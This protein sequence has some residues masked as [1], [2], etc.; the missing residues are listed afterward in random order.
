MLLLGLVTD[1]QGAPV[2]S[3]AAVLW[4]VGFL[5]WNVVVVPIRMKTNHAA[6][7]FELV[8]LRRI[9]AAG[10]WLA[11]TIPLCVLFSHVASSFFSRACSYSP[12]ELMGEM[13]ENLLPPGLAPP[14][15]IVALI[16]AQLSYPLMEEFFFRGRYLQLL[17][18]FFGTHS[19]IAISTILFALAHGQT[20]LFL[21][22]LIA[23][24]VYAY[25]VVGTGSIWAGVALHFVHNFFLAL[26]SSS[27]GKPIIRIAAAL[28]SFDCRRDAASAV[29]LAAVLIGVCLFWGRIVSR[30]GKQ[31]TA[32]TT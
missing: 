25:A 16:A 6:A 9:P 32:V 5:V 13:R 30:R 17:R 20:K 19:A 14:F 31:N 23:G 2:P 1:A 21:N 15:A 7:H 26:A 11:I 27:E 28:G 10:L 4:V 24:F 29:I 3:S 8:P 12:P 22:H 18:L